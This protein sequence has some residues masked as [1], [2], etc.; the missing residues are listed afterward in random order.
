MPE[1]IGESLRRAVSVSRIPSGSGRPAS[2][3]ANSGRQDA[4]RATLNLAFARAGAISRASGM[5]RR[6]ASWHLL[7]LAESGLVGSAI[8]KGATHNFPEGA[9]Q[10]QSLIPLLG[11]L[12]GRAEAATL[13]EIM[14]EPGL[15]SKGLPHKALSRLE[16]A[17]LITS[18]S[19]GRFRRLYPG[20][21]VKLLSDSLRAGYEVHKALMFRVLQDGGIE[22]KVQP[23]RDGSLEFSLLA[24]PAGFS[25][26][27]PSN[28]MEN[29]LMQRIKIY[30][31]S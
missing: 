19:D 22:F 13:F 3:L 4:Y 16:S 20:A 11:L 28:P 6:S 26:T 27:M 18:V 24:Q 10:D 5:S 8:W 9:I 29:S 12:G 23:Q 15:P 31:I 1:K 7:T 2:I 25:F 21:G 30:N 14:M 17:S